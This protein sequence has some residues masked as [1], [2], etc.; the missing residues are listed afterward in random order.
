MTPTRPAICLA[1]N[2]ALLMLAGLLAGAAIPAVPYPRIML[3]AHTAGFTDSGLISILAGVLLISSL[4][5]L[6]PACGKY[7]CLGSRRAVAPEPR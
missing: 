6:P 4:C 7:G 1:L 3:A 5:S 2:G